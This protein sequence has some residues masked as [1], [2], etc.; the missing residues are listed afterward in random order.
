[1]L[2]VNPPWHFDEEAKGMV[3]WLARKLVISGR[4]LAV[5][6]WLVPE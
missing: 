4:S 5:V 1:M 2:I 6:E 3:E